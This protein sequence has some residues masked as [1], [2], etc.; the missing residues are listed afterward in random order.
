MLNDPPILEG[1][2]GKKTEPK[3][4]NMPT[5]GSQRSTIG[6]VNEI[7]PNNGKESNGKI[8]ES[9]KDNSGNELSESQNEYFKDSKVRDENGNLMV[10]YH[11]TPSG[12]FTV[13]R[14]GSY[15]TANKEYASVYHSPS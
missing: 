15:F 3:R 9:R 11:G 6:S 13:F 7:I 12:N 5:K 4:A 14:D 10:M 8:K 2:I 1:H